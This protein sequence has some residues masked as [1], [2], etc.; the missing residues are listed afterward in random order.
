VR[1]EYGVRHDWD[2]LAGQWALAPRASIS[3][4]PWSHTRLSAGY[5]VS[6]DETSL[7]LFSRP[8]DQRPVTTFFSPDGTL[9]GIPTI[10]SA[11]VAPRGLGN[12]SYRTLSF[13]V[14][15]RLSRNFRLTS[16]VLRKRG[17]NGLTYISNRGVFDLA[18]FK[19]DVYNSA[20][21][22]VHHTVDSL[23]EWSA[24]YTRSGTL[25]NAVTDINADQTRIVKNNFGRMGWDV[26]DRLVSGGYLPTPLKR[27]SVAYL[28]DLHEGSPFSVDSNGA[29]VGGVNSR[30]FPSFFEL[31]FHLEYRMTLFKKRLALRAGF[32]NITDHNNPT[33]V[34]STIGSPNYLKF[35]GSDPR[36]L[37]FRLRA[38]GKE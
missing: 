21:I 29:V 6:H 17:D 9:A 22:A 3:Y 7:L 32:N 1:V 11:Y 15:R 12:G 16:N 26:P 35:Y 14:E 19:K 2:R 36:R 30:R 24:S 5:A 23:H 10:G 31:D 4:A 8:F 18:N 33:A 38:L 13:G 20:D 28:L 34:N 25:S 27:W 37:V